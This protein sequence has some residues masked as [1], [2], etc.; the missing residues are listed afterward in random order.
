MPDEKLIRCA[1]CGQVNRVSEKKLQLGLQ[2][3]C[4]R[5]KQPLLLNNIPTNLSDSTFSD[6]VEKS[7]IPVLVDFW[8]P[9]CGPCHAMAPVIEQ[10]ANEMSGKIV[11]GK[12]DTDENP[13]VSSRFQI[14]SIPTLILFN[15]GKE[16]DRL[17]GVRPKQEIA[18]RIQR[19]LS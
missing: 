6:F 17:I 4:G 2:P 7:S 19:V 12:L 18:S 11:V 8:A 14:Q 16:V 1:S 13:R 9:W 5:C 3:K 10:L 15:N